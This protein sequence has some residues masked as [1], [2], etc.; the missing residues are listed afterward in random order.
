MG[1]IVFD[2]EIVL[3]NVNEIGYFVLVRLFYVLGGRVMEIVYNDEDLIKYM[4]K[5][6][7][8]NFDYL[9]LIDRYLI[10]K[11]IEVDVIFDGENIFIFGIM[12]YIERV[13]V[14]SGDLILIYFF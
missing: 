9:V 8:I 2:V 4:E 6:V 12:E 13:G 11:E 3:K 10:G 14:Y 5:V 1:K 7:Y